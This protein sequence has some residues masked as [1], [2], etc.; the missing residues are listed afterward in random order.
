VTAT[1]NTTTNTISVKWAHALGVSPIPDQT[2]PENAPV[3]VAFT[4]SGEIVGVLQTGGTASNTNLVSSITTAGSGTNFTAS[5]QLVHDASGQSD[6]TITA[7]DDRGSG[8]TT[9]KLT[10]VARPANRQISR[11]SRRSQPSR[12]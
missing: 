10:V 7:R 3:T 1:A 5:V 8:S 9:F 2:V 12:V 6:I 4:V 11:P